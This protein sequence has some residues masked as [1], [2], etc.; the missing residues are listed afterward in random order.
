MDEDPVPELLDM[1]IGLESYPYT[2]FDKAL[3]YFEYAVVS[4]LEHVCRELVVEYEYTEGDGVG[5]YVN[6]Y[7]VKCNN[8]E[9]KVR[10]Y[11]DPLYIASVTDSYLIETEDIG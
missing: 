10:M 1:L 9:Y 8:K 4:L 3:S 6:V 5:S 11:V 2:R 7:K